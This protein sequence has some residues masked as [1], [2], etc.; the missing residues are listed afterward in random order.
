MNAARGVIMPRVLILVGQRS[1]G[2]SLRK[3]LIARF[4]Q[5]TVDLAA[6]IA[7]ADPAIADADVLIVA[8]DLLREEVLRKAVR[9][10]WVQVL[11]VAPIGLIDFASLRREVIVT[12]LCGI[13]SAP[14]CETAL[15]LMLAFV[16]GFAAS[17]RGQR[18]QKWVRPSLSTLFDKTVGILGTGVV[19]LDLAARCKAFGMRVVGISLASNRGPARFDELRSCVDLP[20]AVADLDFLVVLTPLTRATRHCVDAAVFTAM[21]RTSHLINIAGSGVVVETDLVVALERGE[22][23]SAALSSFEQR[24]LP[25]GHPLWTAKNAIIAPQPESYEE[26][27]EEE[28]EQVCQNMDRFI[29]GKTEQMEVRIEL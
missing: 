9:L 19:A 13:Y 10:K 16:R 12:D 3:R 21:K 15:L 18:E 6:D 25:P 8:P 26:R 11:N 2:A 29:A 17:F 22:I 23:A 20:S 14:L 7:E 24:P 4:P 1:Q 5:I 27:C 28:M